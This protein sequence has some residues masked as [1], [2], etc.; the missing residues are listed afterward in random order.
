MLIT[1]ETVKY[2]IEMLGLHPERAKFLL[3]CPIKGMNVSLT[4]STTKENIKAQII[5]ASRL[6]ISFRDTAKMME[7]KEDDLKEFAVIHGITFPKVTTHFKSNCSTYHNF[8][9]D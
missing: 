2:N 8:F 4:N 7:W 9:L 5:E 1:T 3:A 6:G